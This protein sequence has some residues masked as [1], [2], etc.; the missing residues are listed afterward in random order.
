MEYQILVLIHVFLAIIIIGGV[1]ITSFI[2]LPHAKRTNNPA[3][4]FTFIKAFNRGAHATLTIQF[5]VGF[6]LAMIYLPIS[7]WFSFSTSIS[8]T[9]L[10]KLLQWAL[11]FVVLIIGN[12]KIKAAEESGALTIPTRVFGLL[13]IISLTFL[14]LGLNFR[15]GLF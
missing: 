14:V 11:M 1:L 15:L 5:L 4:A 6:R 12:K 3:F 8:L 13:S 7:E 10:L 9:V 2:V